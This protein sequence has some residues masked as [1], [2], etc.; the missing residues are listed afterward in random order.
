MRVQNLTKF[1]KTFKH[2]CSDVRYPIRDSISFG[3]TGDERV[4]QLMCKVYKTS[5]SLRLPGG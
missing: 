5:L 3:E 4:K 2:G 1:P